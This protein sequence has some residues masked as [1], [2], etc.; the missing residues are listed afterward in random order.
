MENKKNLT[1]VTSKELNRL[2]QIE[3]KV[4]KKR[5]AQTLAIQQCRAKKKE[6]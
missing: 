1:T 6:K 4:K 2:R 3:L 5:K